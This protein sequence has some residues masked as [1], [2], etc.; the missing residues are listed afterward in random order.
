MSDQELVNAASKLINVKTTIAQDE[1]TIDHQKTIE[2]FDGITVS[3]ASDN[4]AID[5]TTGAVTHANEDVKVNL[6]ATAK[7]NDATASVTFEVNVL[8]I[9]NATY[10]VLHTFNCEDATPDDGSNNGNSPSKPSYAGGTVVLG[11]PART[12]FLDNA[13]ISNIAND[14]VD[15][16]FGIRMKKGGKVEIQHDDE[17]NVIDLDAAVYGKDKEGFEIR[18]DYSTDGGATWTEGTTIYSLLNQP[19][20]TYR[21]Y[22]PEGV[23]RIAIVGLPTNGNRC[24]IDNIKLMK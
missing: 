11:T 8:K 16:L 18:V 23:K 2:G 22:L 14:K 20:E 7:L 15:G 21:F 19:L 24:N 9:D 1:T 3:W 13:L 6:T 10:E 4:T 12:W 5:A 17:Y